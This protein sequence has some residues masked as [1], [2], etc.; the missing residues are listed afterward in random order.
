MDLHLQ[1]QDL[2]NRNSLLNADANR[3]KHDAY[4]LDTSHKYMYFSRV[5]IVHG[6]QTQGSV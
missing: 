4:V 1:L 5:L 3:Y 6:M 2:A